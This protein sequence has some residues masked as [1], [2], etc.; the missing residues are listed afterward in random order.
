MRVCLP[1]SFGMLEGISCQVEFSWL[2]RER[3][4]RS[5]PCPARDKKGRFTFLRHNVNH[6]NR[7]RTFDLVTAWIKSSGSAKPDIW[8]WVEHVPAGWTSNLVTLATPSMAQ[9]VTGRNLRVQLEYLNR[10]LHNGDYNLRVAF[11]RNTGTSP[12]PREEW[13]IFIMNWSD[14]FEVHAWS[15]AFIGAFLDAQTSDDSHLVGSPGSAPDV[16]TVPARTPD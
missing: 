16:V 13:R 14:D 10:D 12:L 15:A 11:M 8:A 4:R 6:R 2:P 1:Q 9:Q 5:D 7:R 3:S